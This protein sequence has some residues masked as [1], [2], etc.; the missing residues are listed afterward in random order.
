MLLHH[1]EMGDLVT[2]SFTLKLDCN[3]HD[4]KEVSLYRLRENP[5]PLNCVRKHSVQPHLAQLD[6]KH[7]F[8]ALGTY[9]FQA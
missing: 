1:D 8:H 6:K 2:C 4:I 9:V 7:P 3:A 5:H